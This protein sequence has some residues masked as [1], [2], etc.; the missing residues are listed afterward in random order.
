[1]AKLLSGSRLLQRNLQLGKIPCASR[2]RSG[3]PKSLLFSKLFGRW[4]A[5]VDSN[6]GTIIQLHAKG[7]D[8]LAFYYASREAPWACAST[9]IYIRGHECR[10]RQG[11]P[12]VLRQVS[13]QTG[14]EF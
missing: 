9:C 8:V 6:S 13:M 7:Q 4:C 10:H 12:G 11:G 2:I 5:S 1:M 14:I 3:I